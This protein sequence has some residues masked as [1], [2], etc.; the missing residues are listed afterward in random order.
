MA[1]ITIGDLT[2]SA[3]IDVSDT[4]LASK[5]QLT[6]LKT[7][8][9]EVMAALPKP[10]T[11]PT[12]KDEKFAAAFEKPAIPLKGNTVDAKASVNSTL[13][14]SRKAD[15]PLFGNDDYDAIEIKG[16]DC[17]AGFELDTLLDA[18]V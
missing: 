11:D 13:S 9:S 1:Q 4:S 14:V 8:A 5:N 10:V 15:S 16:D 17:W 3:Q 12:F 2:G 7:A 18:S 6:A